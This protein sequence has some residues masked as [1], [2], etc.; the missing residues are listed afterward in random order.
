MSDEKKPSRLKAIFRNAVV[1]GTVWGALGTVVAAIMRLNDNIPAWQ[2]IL[3]GIGMG[4]RIGFAGGVTGAMFAAFISVAYRGRRLSEINWVKFGLGGLIF[5]GLFVPGAMETARLL[6]GDPWLP[7]NLITGDM[8][9][10]ALFGGIT[11]AGTMRLAQLA[12]Q[13][14]PAADEFAD[15]VEPGSLGAGDMAGFSGG[16]KSRA[17][18]RRA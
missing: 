6:S 16:M 12:E 2:A 14:D 17:P 11:A 1:W 4:V 13:K 7:L 8:I 15:T 5:G 3:D 18:E 10:S 9:Y